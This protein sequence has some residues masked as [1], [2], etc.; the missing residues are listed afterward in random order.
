M[1]QIGA[2]ICILLGN[3]GGNK[4]LKFYQAS[5]QVKPFCQIIR[6]DHNAPAV[7]IHAGE[8]IKMHKIC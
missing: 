5:Y 2:N 8:V 6:G 3:Y 4:Y 7:D 1:R